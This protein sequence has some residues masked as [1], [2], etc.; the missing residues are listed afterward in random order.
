MVYLESDQKLVPMIDILSEIFPNAKFIW[1]IRNPK[2]FLKSAKARGW[3]LNDYPIISHKTVLISPYFTS[4][5]CRITGSVIGEFTEDNWNELSQDDKILWYWDY[6]NNLIQD[7]FEKV[8]NKKL[9][10]KLE[11]INSECE[12]IFRFIGNKFDKKWNPEIT[13]KVI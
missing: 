13:N 7:Q 1:L 5:A 10:I 8:S 9:V 4:D 2:S 12:N 11:N 3:F 6:W